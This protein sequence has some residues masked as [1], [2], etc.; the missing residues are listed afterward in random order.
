MKIYLDNNATTQIDPLVEKVLFDTLHLGPLNA[1]SIHSYGNKAKNI[2]TKSR[3]QI[4]DY[5]LVAPQEIIFT[6][7]AT[8]SLNGVLFGLN[9]KSILTSS[10][11]H[12][13]I[14]NTCKYL[15]QLGVKVTYLNPTPGGAIDPLD[16]Q[17]ALENQH[18]DLAI[19]GGANSETGVLNDYPAICS[20]CAQFPVFCMIDTVQ[21]MGKEPFEIV[22]GM[23]ACCFSAH[24]FHGPCGIGFTYL[25]NSTQI[26]P[27]LIGGGQEYERR[28]GTQSIPLIASMAQAVEIAITQ[29]QKNKNH[30]QKLKTKLQTHLLKNPNVVENS[31][32]K[33][34]CN[35]LNLFFKE[36]DGD[37]LLL[38]LDLQGICASLGSAC[39]SGSLE[40]SRVL[41]NMG[42]S[43]QR[44][45]A[46]LRFSLSRF[47]TEDEID[48]TI[49]IVDQMNSS[50][51]S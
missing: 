18:Y 11:E 41:L 2:L 21:L 23:D 26:K 40:P 9:P 29:I 27:F 8:E 19:F 38:N 36:C 4:A 1:S 24:K 49:Q 13:A 7:C 33:T 50:L 28:A 45:L 35:T 17:K 39:S 46:S 31:K 37:A 3:R 20:I 5:L 16:V 44:A 51:H 32:K 10:I 25:K 47:T 14:Y 48:Q 15:E 22:D 6:S 30:M 43:K 12:S 34:L 42:F